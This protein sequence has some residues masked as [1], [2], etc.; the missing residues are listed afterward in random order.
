MSVSLDLSL[1]RS[2]IQLTAWFQRL[3]QAKAGM[4]WARFVATREEGAGSC[5]ARHGT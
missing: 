4:K 3:S 5:R 2:L 1:S